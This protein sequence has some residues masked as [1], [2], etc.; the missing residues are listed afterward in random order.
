MNEP[1]PHLFK[2][3]KSIAESHP[4][5][6]HT[7]L[8][9]EVY[10]SI[11]PNTESYKSKLELW[12]LVKTKV[13]PPKKLIPRVY[14]ELKKWRCTDITISVANTFEYTPL[15]AKYEVQKDASYFFGYNI[16][17]TRHIG[18]TGYIHIAI[19]AI[20]S[21]ILTVMEDG[22]YDTMEYRILYGALDNPSTSVNLYVDA[23]HRIRNDVCDAM[24]YYHD[25]V[26]YRSNE[27]DEYVHI[28]NFIR[29]EF[30]IDN[31]TL[32]E[33]KQY[34]IVGIVRRY[35]ETMSLIDDYTPSEEAIWKCVYDL[36]RK[37]I[38]TFTEESDGKSPVVI[39]NNLDPLVYLF[40]P[41][42]SCIGTI[43]NNT[44]FV[45]VCV[46]IKTLAVSG[47]YI[48]YGKHRINIDRNGSCD[49]Y[50]PGFFDASGNSYVRLL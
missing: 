2:R 37:D 34:D 23:Q 50:P 35:F 15:P 12:K 48:M 16:K 41:D 47:Y 24:L 45:D 42:G 3:I 8:I 1:L 36:Y 17:F 11:L 28:T 19:N 20:H 7:E 21:D 29:K 32:D 40:S 26:M 5:N 33:I 4:E 6:V 25:G 9:D 39:H 38:R 49:S 14:A 44:A 22:I 43:R 31:T 46:Q 30:D 10:N 13:K 18:G 27:N